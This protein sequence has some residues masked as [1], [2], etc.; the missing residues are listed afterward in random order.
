M[1]NESFC[2]CGVSSAWL[3]DRMTA[4]NVWSTFPSW[5]V[6]FPDDV[7][8]VHSLMSAIRVIRQRQGYWCWYT[9]S[10]ARRG[11]C[12]LLVQVVTDLTGCQLE[13]TTLTRWHGFRLNRV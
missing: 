7:P 3:A 1:Q 6:A 4:V 2:H 11:R 13:R 12:W 10:D 8:P 5:P 9:P